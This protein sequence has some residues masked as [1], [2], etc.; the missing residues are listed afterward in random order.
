MA[1]TK[2]EKTVATKMSKSKPWTAIFI[3]DT[4]QEIMDKINRSWCP[5]KLVEGNPILAIIRSVIYHE[6]KAFTIERPVKFGGE[7]S[8]GTYDELE[9]AYLRGEVHPADLK[10]NVAEFLDK[11]LCPIRDH[12]ESNKELLDIYRE[13]Q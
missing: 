11:I 13:E 8:F 12:F 2:D 5:P 10:A 3:H 7:I 4:K 6:T 9:A 1:Q